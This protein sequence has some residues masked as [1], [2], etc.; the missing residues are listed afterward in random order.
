MIELNKCFRLLDEGF[1]VLFADDAKRPIGSWKTL[2][3]KAYTKEQLEQAY[4]NPKNAL[5]GIIT[6]YN[7]LEVIDI[8]LKDYFNVK[9]E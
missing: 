1:S 8:D 6:G 9:Q 4:T 2:Q 7:N 3:E 5:A